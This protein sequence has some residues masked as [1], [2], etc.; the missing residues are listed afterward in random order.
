MA[1]IAIIAGSPS[2]Q[3]RLN[4][5]LGFIERELESEGHTASRIQVRDLPPDD[6]IYARFESERIA[7]ANAE[8]ERADGVIVATP[9][10]K[11]AYTGVLKSYLDLLPQNALAGKVLLPV[12]IGGTLAHLLVNEYALKPVLAALGARHIVSGVYAVDTD[13]TAKENGEYEVAEAL[14]ERL[15]RN[16]RQLTDALRH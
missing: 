11:A 8:V 15:S 10:Y 14:Q 1:H 7:Q 3:T 13:V 16:V 4:G 12:A 5:L 9:V 6:L 2:Q